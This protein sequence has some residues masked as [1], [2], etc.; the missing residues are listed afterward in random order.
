MNKPSIMI[1]GLPRDWIP[2]YGARAWQ[3]SHDGALARSPHFT[4]R[5]VIPANLLYRPNGYEI[6]AKAGIS[7][8]GPPRFRGN[9]YAGTTVRGRVWARGRFPLSRVGDSRPGGDAASSAPAPSAVNP[10]SALPTPMDWKALESSLSTSRNC[11]STAPRVFGP[12]E[13]DRL[14]RGLLSAC[15]VLV[16]HKRIRSQRLCNETEPHGR[17]MKVNGASRAGPMLSISA[18]SPPPK[19]RRMPSGCPP[20]SFGRRAP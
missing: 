10:I 4:Q 5:R 19:S 9:D 8:G 11:A 1:H 7:A 17:P 15:R 2:A 18:P 6:P 20:G 16:N 13:I 3:G 14:R 12:Y